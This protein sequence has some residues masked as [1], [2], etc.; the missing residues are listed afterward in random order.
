MR[1]RTKTS[2]E[3]EFGGTKYVRITGITIVMPEPR[4]PDR[5]CSMRLCAYELRSDM[6]GADAEANNPSRD[7]AQ[8]WNSSK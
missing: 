6:F 7:P 8:Q 4:F 2:H 5:A 3:R 1:T